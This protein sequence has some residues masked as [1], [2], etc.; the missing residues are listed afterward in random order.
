MEVEELSVLLIEDNEDILRYAS[1]SIEREGITG[2][3]TAKNEQEA[4]QCFG[5]RRYDL[6]ISDTMY[7]DTIPMGPNAVRKAKAQ[8]H[9]PV[10]VALSS[11]TRNERL[12]G[13]LADYF[14]G[15]FDFIG[16]ES[17]LLKKVLREK[18][19]IRKK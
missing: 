10:V 8:G 7:G 2:Y 19:Q 16:A 1:R 13:D 9:T 14:F 15:K 18:F 12:W 6:V 4:E 17:T 11:S 3:D 5:R